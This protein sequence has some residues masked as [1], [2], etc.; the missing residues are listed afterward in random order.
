MNSRPA[1][2]AFRPPGKFSPA[3]RQVILKELAVFVLPRIE[4]R[5]DGIADAGRAVDD[6]ERRMEA[7]DL[8]FA[9]RYFGGIF[10]GDP[11]GIDAVH[12][13][14]IARV[15]LSGCAR[16]HIERGLGHIGV[17]MFIGLVIPIELA[18]HGRDIDDVFVEAFVFEHQR[19]ELC[20]EHKGRDGVDQ[21][22]LEQFDGGNFRE[23]EAPTVVCA[24]ID[25]LEVLIELALGK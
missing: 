21:V 6:I 14:S 16:E 15:V 25:L 23:R 10:I 4:A 24:K 12:E 5:K 9:R 8:P 18:L 20:A 11:S 3:H 1:P 2:P 22:N 17:G 7:V 19:L 13:N